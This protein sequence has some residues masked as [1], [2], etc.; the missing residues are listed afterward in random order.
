MIDVLNREGEPVG[1]VQRRPGSEQVAFA[2]SE[3]R[4]RLY[5]AFERPPAADPGQDPNHVREFDAWPG[6]ATAL[7]FSPDGQWIASAGAPGGVK[8][9]KVEG[10]GRV[11]SWEGQGGA[12][13]GL[14]FDPAGKRLATAGSDGRLRVLAMPQGTLVTNIEPVEVRRMVSG[15]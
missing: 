15:Q 7:A 13:F 8:V 14:A 3:S 12:V 2:G 4:V 1:Q 11:S 6:G 10:G 9:Q 5:Q